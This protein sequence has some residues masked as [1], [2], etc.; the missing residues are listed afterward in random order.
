[1]SSKPGGGKAA[2]GLHQLQR[3]LDPQRSQPRVQ[4][5]DVGAD[6]GLNIGVDNR[7][8]GARILLDLRQDLAADGDR[9][10][11]QRGTDSSGHRVLVGRIGIAVQQAD[12]DAGYRLSSQHRDT[13]TDAGRVERDRDRAV[14]AHLLGHFQTQPPL[15]QRTRL[16]PTNVVQHRHAQIADFQYVAKAARGDQRGS[17]TFAF[18]DGVRCRPSSHATHRPPGLA[19]RPTGRAIRQRSPRH[20]RAGW[21]RS[22]ASSLSRPRVIATRSVKVPPI[23]TPIRRNSCRRLPGHG[24]QGFSV[25]AQAGAQ[26]FGRSGIDLPADHPRRPR[27]NRAPPPRSSPVR[28]ANHPPRGPDRA[29]TQAPI[30]RHPA[31]RCRKISS[32]FR[33]IVIFACSFCFGRLAWIEHVH[34]GRAGP[35]A[36]TDP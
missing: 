29:P 35:A 4:S 17:G 7:R 24:G 34:P 22:C 26:R 27:H 10:I 16:G 2:V 23:S 30:P 19:A 13:R 3:R 33:F 25:P 8:A 28:R 11:R 31:I 15:D 12:S 5:G 9:D 20:S 14:R 18:Q 1:M 32:R 6:N 21:K 36:R